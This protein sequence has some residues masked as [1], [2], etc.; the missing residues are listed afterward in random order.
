[1]ISPYCILCPLLQPP[2]IELPQ[3]AVASKEAF[4]SFNILSQTGTWTIT[5]PR[6]EKFDRPRSMCLR[7]SVGNQDL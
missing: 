2:G 1:M 5:L 3:T 7:L 4:P 6:V